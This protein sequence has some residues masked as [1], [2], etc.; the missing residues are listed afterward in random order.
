MLLDADKIEFQNVPIWLFKLGIP[1]GG[2]GTV[3]AGGTTNQV[4]AK[5]SNANFDTGWVNQSGGG[6]PTTAQ[7]LTGAADGTLTAERVV[8][9]TTTIAWDLTTASQAKANVPNGSLTDVQI[10]AANKDGA[11]GTASMRTLGTGAQQATAGN[12]SRLSD[13]RTP[14]AHATTHE[15]GGSDPM[16][17]DAAPGV[18]SLRTLGT[19]ANQACAGNDTRLGTLVDIGKALALAGGWALT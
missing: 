14:T 18:G 6:A 13:S 19:G 15:P 7:Y 16:T 17:V 5:N 1:G 9:D 10:N 12:D 11:A 4:L 8:T 2:G 3:P